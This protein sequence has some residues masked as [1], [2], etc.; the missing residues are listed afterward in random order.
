MSAFPSAGQEWMKGKTTAS[1]IFVIEA[2]IGLLQLD[3]SENE[4]QQL[5]SKID[6]LKSGEE[7]LTDFEDIDDWLERLRDHHP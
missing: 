2:E 5:R 6:R 7:S 3:L 1:V 4:K